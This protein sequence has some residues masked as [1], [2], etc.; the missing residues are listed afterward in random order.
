MAAKYPSNEIDL[1]LC[2]IYQQN[3]GSCPSLS[4]NNL[5]VCRDYL[6]NSKCLKLNLNG[7][8]SHSH[9]LFTLHNRIIL[10]RMPKLSVQNG[11]EFDRVAQLIRTS[12]SNSSEMVSH[13][14]G[15]LSI[16]DDNHEIELKS[17]TSTI[18]S[19]RDDAKLLLYNSAPE[20][21]SSLY[22]NQSSK[23]TFTSLPGHAT[24]SDRLSLIKNT[25]TP[26][27]PRLSTLTEPSVSKTMRSIT[28]D[29]SLY[30][31]SEIASRSLN[32]R[33]KDFEQPR[34]TDRKISTTMSLSTFKPEYKG[35]FIH[36]DLSKS[37]SE[38][39][40][41]LR[42]SPI[43]TT[44]A[45]GNRKTKRVHFH[46]EL[47]QEDSTSS[48]FNPRDQIKNLTQTKYISNKYIKDEQLS[49]IL[50]PGRH[51]MENEGCQILPSGYRRL[52]NNDQEKQIEKKLDKLLLTKLKSDL[53][54]LNNN[55]LTLMIPT[56]AAERLFEEI[57]IE[58][59]RPARNDLTQSMLAASSNIIPPRTPIRQDQPYLLSPDGKLRIQSTN[60]SIG[61]VYDDISQV[62]VDM[63]VCVTT[64]GTLL[65]SV[66]SRAG[67]SIE[68]EYRKM[69]HST[70]DIILGGGSTKARQIICAAWKL[71]V[72]TSDISKIQ[73][74]LS[75]LVKRCLD[76]AVQR[77]MRS[78]SFPPIGTGMIGLDPNKVCESMVMTA[79]E[80]LNKCT[81]DVLFVIYPSTKSDHNQNTYQ[82]FRAYLANFCQQNG[83]KKVDIS[84]ATD[85]SQSRSIPVDTS[86]YIRRTLEC[87]QIR[88]VSADLPNIVDY[89]KE[90][91][92]LL[93][94]LIG[95][96][97]Y[98]LFLVQK[99]FV[100]QVEHL[101]DVCLKYHILPRIDFSKNKLILRGDRESCSQCFANL[102]QERLI[103]KYYI[104]KTGNISN[105]IK[106]N[107]YESMKID[108]AFSVDKSKI[109]IERDNNIIFDIDVKTSQVEI[110]D[111]EKPAR[112]DR[113]PLNADSKIVPPST[114]LHTS[115]M[116]QTFSISHLQFNSI[117]C[118][119]VFE[120]SMPKSEWYIERVDAIQNWPLYV[121]YAGKKYKNDILFFH[122]CPFSSVQSIIHYGLHSNR[123]GQE[124]LIRLTSVASS[125]H[126]YDTRRSTDGKYYMF[127]VQLSSKKISDQDCICLSNEDAH[128]ALPTYLI[129]YH[130]NKIN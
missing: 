38:I 41:R 62:Q 104:Y 34:K 109:R 80:H 116:I 96:T 27:S 46:Y 24:S 37:F 70:D 94:E 33:E 61:V 4:C 7:R 43:A 31:T 3:S 85:V 64:S 123:D 117:E 119:R 91:L 106:L 29:F 103:H 60:S 36:N 75:N 69:Q 50:G 89:H 100:D 19:G 13:S 8:C 18:T 54:L 6:L 49:Y 9:S 74:S 17:G 105:E 55:E 66:L 16:S 58:V 68:S 102:R 111:D 95:E 93:K 90:L 22:N 56:S 5:H 128:L 124:S 39:D 42:T 11:D 99:P 78:I 2:S 63:M 48:T 107:T 76:H 45:S 86:Q 32:L 84:S 130:R 113:K 77:K 121:H 97:T 118:I 72:H 52:T 114:W 53:V 40:E 10:D 101:V 23:S 120:R 14:V 81:M 79:I 83:S 20:P 98:D 125:T 26:V 88:T 44:T 126:I 67:P 110:Y 15:R 28:P 122:G 12:E 127:A 115:L 73:K 21:S 57:D 87:K 51:L 129:V 25:K 108:E 82:I 71:E 35:K 47:G 59:I 92:K 1:R 65:K 30:P 112:L